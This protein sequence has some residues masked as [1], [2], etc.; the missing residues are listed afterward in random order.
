M[1]KKRELQKRR[2]ALCCACRPYQI[3]TLRTYTS[4]SMLIIAQLLIGVRVDHNMFK[5]SEME[6]GK[7]SITAAG[8]RGWKADPASLH[9][10]RRSM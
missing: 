9:K 3:F 1:V 5:V 2:A 10:N 4:V 8:K 6:V 7:D